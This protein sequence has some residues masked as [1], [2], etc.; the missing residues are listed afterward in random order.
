MKTLTLR[1]ILQLA[2]L[3]HSSLGSCSPRN[4]ADLKKFAPEDTIERDVC[5]LGGGA[6]GAYSAIRLR[7]EGKSVVVLERKGRLGGNTETYHDEKTGQTTEAG[8]ILYHNRSLVTDLFGRYNIELT[9][10][11]MISMPNAFADFGREKVV[12]Y[13]MPDP[14]QPLAKYA[15]ILNQYPFLANGLDFPDPVP[16]DISMP[17]GEFVTKHGLEDMVQIAWMISQGIGNMLERPTL[18]MMK[19]MGLACLQSIMQGFL[20]TKDNNNSALY[21]KITEELG[22]DAIINSNIVSVKR[23]DGDDGVSVVFDNQ[24]HGQ[25]LVKA[26]KLLVAIQ[27]TLENLRAFDLNEEEQSIFGKFENPSYYTLVLKNVNTTKVQNNF[28]IEKP[29]NLPNLPATYNVAPTG[30]DN[31][32]SVKF[33]SDPKHLETREVQRAVLEDIRRLKGIGILESSEPE[34]VFY[35]DHSPINLGVSGSEIAGGFYK[36]LNS[37]QGKKN[38]FFTG[39]AFDAQDSTLVWSFSETI[40]SKILA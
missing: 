27:P 14:V 8:V 15:A 4:D 25:K 11:N 13:T 37:L 9:K 30:I 31:V 12:N 22:E 19:T 33:A 3:L 17:F 35:S 36:R 1:R 23:N 6:S 34:I 40:I 5:I 10:S 24:P 18:Y 32:V 2:L 26:K 21:E 20:T 38:T 39:A 29:L 16:S 7:D 28:D